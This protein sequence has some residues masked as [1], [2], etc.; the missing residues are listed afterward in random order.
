MCIRT[1]ISL[2]SVCVCVDG[3]S[4]YVTVRIGDGGLGRKLQNKQKLITGI[5]NSFVFICL[6][7]V[8]DNQQNIL[9]TV[10]RTINDC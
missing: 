9:H 2:C 6:A 10:Q 5:V 1:F 8:Y 7:I 4:R 3:C